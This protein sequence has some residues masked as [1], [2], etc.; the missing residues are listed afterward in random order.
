VTSKKSL[1][2]VGKEVVSVGADE[3]EADRCLVG[4][5]DGKSVLLSDGDTVG[6]LDGTFVTII[7]EGSEV[8]LDE[9]SEVDSAVGLDEGS[10]VGLDEG[11]EVNIEVKLDKGSVMGNKDGFKLGLDKVSEVGIK[12]G[13]ELDT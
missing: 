8:G 7:H 10:E 5:M 3:G 4:E 6:N 12:E 9:G 1:I 2:K 11:P 13:L